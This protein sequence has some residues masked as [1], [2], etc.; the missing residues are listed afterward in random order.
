[1]PLPLK[2]L[3][4][5]W[6]NGMKITR[7]HLAGQDRAEDDKIKD[8]ASAFLNRFSYGLL[9]IW[10]GEQYSFRADFKADNQKFLKA[11]L[12]DLRAFTPGGARIEIAGPSNPVELQVD[13]TRE[14]EAS[15]KEE[16]SWYYIVLSVDLFSREPC[17]QPDEMEEPPRFPFTAP[18]VRMQVI[19]VK[20]L[21]ASA[22]LP[23]S[24]CIGK[25]LIRPEKIEILDDYLPPCMTLSSHNRLLVFH[26]KV[27]KFYNQM[28]INLLSIIGKIREKGQDSSLALSVL[29]LA[30]GLL[31]YLS[32]NNLAVKW[33]LPGHPPLYLFEN[34][35]CF[36]RI[37]RNTIDSNTAAQ[38]EELL[39]YFTNWSEL[40]QGDLE[41]LLVFCINFEYKHLEI[42]DHISQFSEFI[43]IMAIL[44][45]KL[46]SLAFIGKKK[47]TNIFVKEQTAKRSFLAD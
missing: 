2:Y 21:A 17:G 41:K 27:E 24:L 25:M 15:K 39:N 38:K 36:A 6:V 42:A 31:D 9:P 33:L 28:E 13:L 18:A 10:P 19:P 22:L 26:S 43:Q 30:Q 8:V 37:M 1:M 35:A 4:V 5:N 12:F 46:E 11:S 44:F 47:E 29:A 34:I 40:K 23:Y 3:N 16:S 14:I 7:E 32:V 45:S 20:E